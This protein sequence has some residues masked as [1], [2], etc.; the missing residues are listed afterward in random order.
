MLRREPTLLA[1]GAR[2]AALRAWETGGAP[3]EPLARQPLATAASLGQHVAQRRW[4]AR[5]S[6]HAQHAA[7]N[8]RRMFDARQPQ[9]LTQPFAFGVHELRQHVAPREI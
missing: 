4:R 6:A 1:T 5:P 8:G 2:I 9:L 3:V 7:A